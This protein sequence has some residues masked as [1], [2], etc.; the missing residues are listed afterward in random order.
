MLIPNPLK[1]YQKGLPP[2]NFA[3]LYDGILKSDPF[4]SLLLYMSF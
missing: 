2:K 1:S 4:L 3:L